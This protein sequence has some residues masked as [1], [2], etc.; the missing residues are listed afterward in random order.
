MKR[1]ERKALMPKTGNVT[2]VIPVFNSFKKS[3]S[4]RLV[5]I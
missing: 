4:L 1:K 3:D 5:F 2:A